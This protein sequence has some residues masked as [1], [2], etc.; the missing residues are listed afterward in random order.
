[1]AEYINREAVIAIIDHIKNK[2]AEKNYD[3]FWAD[4]IRYFDKKVKAVPTADVAEIVRCKDCL[5]WQKAV[6][7]D[8]DDVGRCRWAKYMVNASD[9]CS[10]GIAKMGG[11]E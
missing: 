11:E 6:D 1:M 5:Y 9:Y 8:F 3:K 7:E 4:T 2:Y 10:H